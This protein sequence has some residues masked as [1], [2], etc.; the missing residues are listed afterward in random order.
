MLLS[1]VLQKNLYL[2]ALINAFDYFLLFNHYVLQFYFK[3][4]KHSNEASRHCP[5]LVER[6]SE[7]NKKKKIKQRRG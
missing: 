5:L 4:W 1:E 3:S 2:P 6:D 7:Q